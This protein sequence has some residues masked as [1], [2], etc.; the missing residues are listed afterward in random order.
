MADLNFILLYVEDVAASEA[1][2][3]QNPRP[4]SGRSRRR[5]SP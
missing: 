5:T 4:P 2:Y 3:A 1:F